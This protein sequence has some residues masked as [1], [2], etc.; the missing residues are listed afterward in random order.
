MHK[1]FWLI[2]LVFLMGAGE[3]AV[4]SLTLKNGHELKVYAQPAIEKNMLAIHDKKGRK[5]LISKGLID[6]E[7]T[8]EIDPEIYRL[9]YP[10]K[11]KVWLANRPKEKTVIA[12]PKKKIVITNE[13]LDAMEPG[14][15]IAGEWVSDMPAAGT[16]AAEAA[17]GADFSPVIETVPG[18]GKLD[19]RRHMVPSRFVIFDFY[20]DWCG[21]CR[22]LTPQLESL[23]KQYPNRIALKKVDIIRWGTPVA[24][25]F[26]IRSIPY[27]EVY[28]DGGKRK[29]SGNGFR[30]LSDL[31]R[32]AK[33]QRW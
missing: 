33:K 29:L 26:N 31:K 21:P 13:T 10:E 11:A 23:V 6:W 12:K 1:R 25:Q 15:G 2:G 30:V 16:P 3:K 18:A 24:D 17:K 19:I 27:V 28:D 32:M 9:A 5:I 8:R 14:E 22:Q 20:A 7:A 4:T